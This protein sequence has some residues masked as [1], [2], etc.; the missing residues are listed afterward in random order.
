VKTEGQASCWNVRVIAAAATDGWDRAALRREQLADQDVGHIPQEV[1]AG[2][3]PEWK[4]IADRSPI[5]KSYWAQRKSLAVRD[6]VLERNWES[7]AGRM[8]TAQIVLPPSKVKE[9]LA[10]LHGG[11]SGG[12]LGVNKTL[13]KV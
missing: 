10:E 8:K 3:R 1:E 11:P 7:A 6:G 5:Y 13:D 9:V 2:Q 4:D 12:H